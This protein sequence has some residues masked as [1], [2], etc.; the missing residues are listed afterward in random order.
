MSKSPK[1][2]GHTLSVLAGAAASHT[3]M[4]AKKGKAPMVTKNLM[5]KQSST[6]GTRNKKVE[7][8]RTERDKTEMEYVVSEMAPVFECSNSGKQDETCVYA[9]C[10]PCHDTAA[11]K[12]CV[13]C[14][15]NLRLSGNPKYFTSTYLSKKP[16]RPKKCVGCQILFTNKKS[17]GKPV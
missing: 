6:R 12:D 4:P 8:Q 3:K 15:Q 5:W 16:N 10:Q 2:R 9:L 7:T 17:S 11:N 13:D 14:Q 1:K